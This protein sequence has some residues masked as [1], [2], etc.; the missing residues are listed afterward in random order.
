[1]G[2]EVE[3]KGETMR[4]YLATFDSDGWA[5]WCSREGIFGLSGFD[6]FA[7]WGLF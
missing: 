5:L 2:D 6:K 4:V 3:Y 7:E 1:M